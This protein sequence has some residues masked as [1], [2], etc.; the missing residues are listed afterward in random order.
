M[1]CQ[2]YQNKEKRKRAPSQAVATAVGTATGCY[3][4]SEAKNKFGAQLSVHTSNLVF[5]LLSTQIDIRK[6]CLSGHSFK[7]I[8]I[9]PFRC[10]YCKYMQIFFSALPSMQSYTTLWLEIRADTW[11]VSFHL[12]IFWKGEYIYLCRFGQNL[13][14]Y[15]LRDNQVLSCHP[16]TIL[17]L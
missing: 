9:M 6:L 3:V 17:Q 14:A 8:V 2:S 12:H 1:P 15:P 11:D 4:E 5:M 10:L 16:K 13:V 7:I